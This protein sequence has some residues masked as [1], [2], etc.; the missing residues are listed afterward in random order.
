MT[1]LR[2]CKCDNSNYF[3][4]VYE[5]IGHRGSS[6]SDIDAVTHDLKTQRFLFQE[7]KREGES[8]DKAQHWMLKDLCATLRKLPQHFTIWIV[9]RRN[10][11][12]FEFAEYGNT[13]QVI[14]RDEL[15]ERFAAWWRNEPYRPP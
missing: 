14:T 6:F 15:R 7:F 4:R 11:G 1:Q 5:G 10:D 3:D 8:Q 9:V 12:W 13:P 2:H